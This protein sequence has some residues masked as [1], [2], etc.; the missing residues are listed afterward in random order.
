MN[1]VSWLLEWCGHVG[2]SVKCCKAYIA[3]GGGGWSWLGWSLLVL[4]SL[5]Q[6]TRTVNS[7]DTERNI[8]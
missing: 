6:T 4:Q 8:Q 7:E 2:R 3:A 5:C 1:T